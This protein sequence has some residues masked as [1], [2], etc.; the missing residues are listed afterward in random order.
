[1]LNDFEKFEEVLRIAYS[2]VM[3]SWAFD[4]VCSVFSEYF[5]EYEARYSRA[6]PNLRIEQII[7]I[8][9]K[10]PE[11]EDEYGRGIELSCEDYGGLIKQHFETAYRKCNYNINHFFSG[12]IR[13]YR[14]LEV[15]Y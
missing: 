7:A 14:Y 4:E 2:R 13:L 10:M 11:L 8:I 5:E 12:K 9:E 3:P 6:H 15:L 1:M